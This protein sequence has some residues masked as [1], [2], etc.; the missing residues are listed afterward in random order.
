[1]RVRRP[2]TVV[3]HGLLV[4]AIAFA[5][6]ACGGLDGDALDA[7]RRAARDGDPE[8]AVGLYQQY[9][10][11]QPDDYDALKEY[12]LTLGE[13]WAYDG[14]DR[15]PII[16]NLDRLYEM[17][18]SDQSIQGLLSL[19]LIREGQVAVEAG[20]FEEAETVLRRAVAVNPESGAAQYNLGILYT[21]KGELEQA[22][23]QYRAAA[24]K[25]PQIPDLYLRLGRAYLDRDDADRAIT[26]LGLVLELRGVSTYLLPEANCSLARAYT[27]KG[28]A[29]EAGEALERATDS[30]DPF[31][32]SGLLEPRPASSMRSTTRGSQRPASAGRVATYMKT[33]S[34]FSSYGARPIMSIASQGQ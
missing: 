21:Q 11:E 6:A 33:S 34:A 2:T 23:A 22:F 16:E 10:E 1:M 29:R 14:G 24:A 18:P 30:C 25:R 26:T 3:R 7:A 13:R 31:E 27:A 15:A 8:R 19:M 17:R 12:T 28:M 9:L 32:K 20:R 4:V 5:A